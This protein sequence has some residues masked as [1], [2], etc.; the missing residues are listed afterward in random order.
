MVGQI[1]PT[2]CRVGGGRLLCPDPLPTQQGDGSG[3]IHDGLEGDKRPTSAHS[4][5]L[6]P[7]LSLLGGP[8]ESVGT[9]RSVATSCLVSKPGVASPQNPRH[10]QRI[11]TADAGPA[12]PGG[13]RSQ[14]PPAS[15]L[16]HR[17]ALG[18]CFFPRS[19]APRGP[20]CFRSRCQES[21]P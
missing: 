9:R 20:R 7:L 13:A 16:S 10:P 12:D 17:S 8:P 6:S 11:K 5:L 3:S 14:P 18:L 21:A 2:G 19:C 1:Q 15:S 4:S